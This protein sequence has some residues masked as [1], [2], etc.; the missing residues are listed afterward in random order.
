MRRRVA[1]G[2]LILLAA[3]GVGLGWLWAS[4]G[5]R[6]K[7]LE[8]HGVVEIQEIR[9]ASKQ[10]GRVKE[11]LIAEGDGVEPGQPLVI[12]E[13]P[14]LEAKKA[15]EIAQLANLEA[16]LEKAIRGP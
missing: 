4:S 11:G 14:E 6:A 13:A 3:A 2:V 5:A 15:Q 10:G 16:E 9:L 12:I 1:I 8:L 7:V